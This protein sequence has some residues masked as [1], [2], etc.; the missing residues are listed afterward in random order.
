MNNIEKIFAEFDSEIKPM[1]E[2]EVLYRYDNLGLAQNTA[3]IVNKAVRQ[4]LSTS[5]QQ[6][7]AEERKKIVDMINDQKYKKGDYTPD[8]GGYVE[9]YNKAI[10]DSLSI[11]LDKYGKKVLDK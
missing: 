8:D 3:D 11:F 5:I 10:E 2:T 4:F 1:I 6:V 7:L 9:A